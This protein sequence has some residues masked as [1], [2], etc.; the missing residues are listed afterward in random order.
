MVRQRVLIIDDYADACEMYAEFLAYAGYEALQAGDG[1]QGFAIAV[2]ENPDVIVL[3]L[4]LP[5]LSGLELARR[6]KAHRSTGMIP[7]ICLSGDGSVGYEERA[8]GAGCSLAMAKPCSPDE[9]V[10]AIRRLLAG[11]A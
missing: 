9:L 6:L 4:A 7:I 10:E 2:A 11:S 1:L 3:D 5:R 8:L